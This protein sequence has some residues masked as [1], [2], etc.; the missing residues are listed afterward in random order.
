[1]KVLETLRKA[2]ITLNEKCIFSVG[3]VKFLGHIVSKNGVEVDPS[4]AES[5]TQLS[6]PQNVS[7]VRRL[8]EIVNQV[9]QSIDN[10]ATKTEPLRQLLKRENAWIWTP[11]HEKSFRDIK[12]ALSTTPVLAHYDSKLETRV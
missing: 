9:D 3:K 5:I 1:M 11:S 8:L 2:G 7:D 6:Q 10:L 4:K 12:T